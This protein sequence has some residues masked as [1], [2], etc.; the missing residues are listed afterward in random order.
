MKADNVFAKMVPNTN[1]FIGKLMGFMSRKGLPYYSS[2]KIKQIVEE[3][4]ELTVEFLGK[5][6][7]E[8][9]FFLEMVQARMKWEEYLDSKLGKQRILINI[10]ASKFFEEVLHKKGAVEEEKKE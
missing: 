8:A 9:S 4:I 10:G 1:I 2:Q 3:T 6:S 5:I 7:A